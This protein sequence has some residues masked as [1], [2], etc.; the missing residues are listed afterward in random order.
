LS[1][2]GHSKVVIFLRVAPKIVRRGAASERLASA[3]SVKD[4]VDGAW[5]E[6]HQQLPVDLDDRNGGAR[7]HLGA[8]ELALQLRLG[9]GA[10]LDVLLDDLSAFRSQI[11]SGIVAGFAPLR[12][13]DHRDH[14]LRLACRAGAWRARRRSLAGWRRAGVGGRERLE[15]CLPPLR[16]D[17]IP[18]S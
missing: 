1:A 15:P 9:S 11:A 6:A 4:S 16:S 18:S 8:L 14:R 10:L 5:A 2:P 12:P 7:W 13:V 17:F 3:R